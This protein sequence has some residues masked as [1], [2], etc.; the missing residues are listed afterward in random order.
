MK[1][2]LMIAVA[3]LAIA[4]C[5]KMDSTMS[6]SELDQSKYNQAFLKYLG[7]P[8]APNQTWGFSSDAYTRAAFT[9]SQA[10]PAVAEASCPYDAAW[11]AN[12]LTTAKEPT[13][14]TANFNSQTLWSAKDPSRLSTLMNNYQYGVGQNGVTQDDKDWFTTNIK[15]LIE[16]YFNKGVYYMPAGE[17]SENAKLALQRMTDYKGLDYW[18]VESNWVTE[19]KITD[20][21][22]GQISVAASEG[23]S[24]AGAERTIVVTGTWN[25][26]ED[27]RIGSLGKVIVAKDGKIV[28]AEGKTLESVNEAQIVVLP[29]GEISGAGTVA[30][31]NGTDNSLLS[32]NWG[33][34]NVGTFN[35]NGGNFYNYGT[36]KAN[37]MDGGAG[38]SRYYNRNVI[39]IN[40]TGSS[41]NIRIYNGCQFYVK[42]NA[43]IRNYEGINGS[44]LVV[45]GELMFSSSADGTNDPTYVGLAG[46]AL[47]KCATLN[48]N[49]TSWSGPT[50]TEY[51][52]LEITDKIV[53]LNWEQNAPQ[54]GGY[55]ENNIYVKAATWTNVPDGNGYQ[56]GETSTA[57]YKFFH[58]VAN[59]T[60]G[61]TGN[62]TKVK[63]GT[64]EFIP[65][66]DDF[67]KGQSGC[68]PGFTAD[69]PSI[70]PDPDYDI[71]IIAEDLSAEGASDFDF[72]DVVLDV[73][74]GSNAKILLTHA[75]G[76]LPLCIGTIDLDHEVHQLFGVWK[77]DFPTQD[78]ATVEKQVMVNTGAGP[79]KTAVNVP[80]NVAI[81]NAEE[82][83]TKLPLYVYK[84]GTWQEMTAPKREPACKLAVGTDYLVLRERTSIKGEYPLFVEWATNANFT[85]K[86]W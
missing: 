11:V 1:K 31:H 45:D 53:Y 38:N 13:T 78:N 25:L 17:D 3:G 70:I 29:G 75:G 57:D 67:V 21:W 27:Q 65:K 73:K 6:Q 35:N 56:A 4:S 76:T 72:N 86:W 36:L 39:S 80:L 50:G 24:Y 42:N 32:G 28:V 12:Y 19:F 52:A 14:K 16:Y 20:T 22:D 79:D 44:A 40:E 81:A 61:G 71:R 41:A 85:S 8:I 34:I 69:V 30:F 63:D 54:T 58:I 10:A 66:S 5:N 51:A 59:C 77:G 82:A 15:P 55:F 33:T 49:G 47:I 18:G 62:V 46:G 64:T 83:N 43:R 68:T 26:N 2:Y 9:R 7:A 48:N 74:F 23:S 37:K 60:S 84:N